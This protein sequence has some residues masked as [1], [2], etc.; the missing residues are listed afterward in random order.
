MIER[1]FLNRIALHSAHVAPWSVELSTAIEAHLA[2]ADL[3][4]RYWATMAARYAAD[5]S[6][7]HFFAQVAFPN[8]FLQDVT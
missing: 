2:H 7:V 5:K 3:A 6:L 8:G 1:F 4:I